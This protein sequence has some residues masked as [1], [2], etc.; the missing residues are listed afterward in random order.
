MYLIHSCNA[1][2]NHE[3][4]YKKQNKTN[5][6]IVTDKKHSFMETDLWRITQGFFNTCETFIRL[7]MW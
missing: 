7:K 2:F 4:F 3:S 5:Y 1:N 6:D